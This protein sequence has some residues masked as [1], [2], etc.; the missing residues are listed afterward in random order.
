M[1]KFV[2]RHAC[3]Y[4]VRTAMRRR[5]EARSTGVES[6]GM[7]AET[8]QSP[9]V[10]DRRTCCHRKLHVRRNVLRHSLESD[11]VRAERKTIHTRTSFLV[12]LHSAGGQ[13]T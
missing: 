3:P 1:K 2:T 7:A 13:E 9:H 4:L 12:I 6:S 8:P 11:T 5:R 10:H